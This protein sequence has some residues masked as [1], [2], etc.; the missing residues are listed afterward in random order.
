MQ[1][2][3]K[4]IADLDD[5]EQISEIF[6]VKMISMQMGK[7]GKNYLNLILCDK[8]GEIE[9]RMWDKVEPVF[10]KIKKNSFIKAEGKINPYQGRKQFVVFSCTAVDEA[11][12]DLGDFVAISSFNIDKMVEELRM[13]IATIKDTEI[14][15]LANAILE[16]TRMLDGFK[17][18]PAAKG[19][20]HAYSGGLLEHVLS[21]GKL[22][23]FF[24]NHYS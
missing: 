9:A 22:T 21:V 17:Y 19:V 23:E 1:S 14:S 12:I 8:S 11:N 10:E 16:D 5:K 15:A 13:M 20:H 3:I 6:L 7:N 2:K 24:A 4:F 18:A